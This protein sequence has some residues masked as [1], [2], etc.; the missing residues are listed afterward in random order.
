MVRWDHD[1]HNEDVWS[2][3]RICYGQDGETA[4]NPRVD[5]QQHPNT[6]A[7]GKIYSL[8][9]QKMWDYSL[10]TAWGSCGSGSDDSRVPVADDRPSAETA[11]WV[12]WQRP[13]APQY[14]HNADGEARVHRRP[15]PQMHAPGLETT[16]RVVAAFC[17]AFLRWRR[18]WD[19]F[20]PNLAREILICCPRIWSRPTT[21]KKDT[22]VYQLN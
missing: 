18:H 22:S 14:V 6:C 4:F 2:S 15:R 20:W 7:S 3:R 19:T 11:Q 12:L 21:A 9:Q 8:K 13:L 17:T 5:Q 10:H 1:D 16:Y